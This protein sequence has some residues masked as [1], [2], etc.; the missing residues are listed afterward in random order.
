MVFLRLTFL[1]IFWSCICNPAIA[2]NDDLHLIPAPNQMITLDGK[3]PLKKR[4]R[5]YIP[6]Q[7]HHSKDFFKQSAHRFT[8]T[9]FCFVNDSTQA[10]IIYRL[11]KNSENKATYELFIEQPQITINASSASTA[12]QASTT[13]LQ[14]I[15]LA[16]IQQKTHLQA[17]HI[18]DSP[19]YQWRGLMLDVSRHFIEKHKILQILDWMAFYKLNSLHL[20]LTDEPAWRIEI[21]QYP[22]LTSVGSIGNYSQTSETP[23]YYSASD[24]NEIVRYAQTRNIQVIPEIDM[25]GHATAAVR[26]YPEFDGGGSDKHPSFTFHPGKEGTYQFLANILKEV[27]A[28]FPSQMLHL[29]GDEVHYGNEKWMDDTQVQALIKEQNLENVK[30]VEYY[31]MKRMADSVFLLENKLLLWDELIHA[32]LP[33]D[34]TIFFWWRHDKVEQLQ[35]AVQNGYDVVACPRLPL[36]FDF[37]QHQS[38]VSGRKWGGQFNNL[39]SIYEFN[40]E[41]LLPDFHTGSI[42]GI[43]ANVWTETITTENRL[44]FMLFPRITALAESAWSTNRTDFEDFSAR[45]RSHLSL[46]ERQDLSYYHPFNNSNEIKN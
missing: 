33:V 40:V 9:Q 31:F 34:K 35:S 5:V 14:L 23:Q 16:T 38:H 45:V 22:K 6:A 12:L 24:I 46:F 26:A 42:L 7:F 43:Q 44:D 41:S 25:P 36:Y 13:I 8:D 10:D 39:Q 20:H 30:E 4:M 21:E 2:Q 29:G 11:Q 1:L 17:V 28:L 27:D 15:A 19:K 18:I 3:M 37:V 32:D